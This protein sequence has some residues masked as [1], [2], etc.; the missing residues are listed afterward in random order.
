[1][2]WVQLSNVCIS[3]RY[4]H[5]LQNPC[6][7][8][9]ILRLLVCC[10]CCNRWWRRAPHCRTRHG[11]PANVGAP[12]VKVRHAGYLDRSGDCCL[13]LAV[14]TQR[15]GRANNWAAIPSYA[16]LYFNIHF[17][18]HHNAGHLTVDANEVLPPSDLLSVDLRGKLERPMHWTLSGRKKKSP[19]GFIDVV[20]WGYITKVI[21]SKQPEMISVLSVKNRSNFENK[22]YNWLKFAK[23]N[24]TLHL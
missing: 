3:A 6:D 16:N 9:P 13:P 8:C 15:G 22:F 23:Q 7:L 14:Q 4:A 2:E 21:Y 17:N 10:I 5:F 20:G 12:A 19:L 18:I 11:V 1:M 24:K